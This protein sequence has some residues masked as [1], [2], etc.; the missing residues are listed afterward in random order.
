M[1]VDF[2]EDVFQEIMRSVLVV[3]EENE[4]SQ[5]D[6]DEDYEDGFGVSVNIKR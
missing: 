1:G 3:L 5:S 4:A 6:Y 2:C